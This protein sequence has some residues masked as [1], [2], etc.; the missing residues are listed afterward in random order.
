MVHTRTLA[1][2]KGTPRELKTMSSLRVP[3]ACSE[4]T[5]PGTT[6]STS[7]SSAQRNVI[8]SARAKRD[9]IFDRIISASSAGLRAVWYTRRVDEVDLG[10]L[11]VG[12]ASPSRFAV[13]A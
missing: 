5:G 6:W 13:R 7:A 11:V 12:P 4:P 3:C 8:A 2:A 1:P 10:L 9:A